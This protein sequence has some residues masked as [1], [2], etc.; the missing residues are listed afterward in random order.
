MISKTPDRRF[1]RTGISPPFAAE[2]KVK[3]IH[4]VPKEEL[5]LTSV[6]GDAVPRWS[7][8]QSRATMYIQLQGGGPAELPSPS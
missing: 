3:F 7:G 6:D 1:Q 5:A 2:Q 8:G 4:I